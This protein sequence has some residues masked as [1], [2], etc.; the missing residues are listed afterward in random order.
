MAVIVAQS[1]VIGQEGA[2]THPGWRVSR[3]PATRNRAPVWRAVRGPD[4]AV[5]HAGDPVGREEPAGRNHLGIEGKRPSPPPCRDRAASGPGSGLPG[6]FPGGAHDLDLEI[7]AAGRPMVVGGS[8][9]GVAQGLGCSTTGRLRAG[10]EP[11][12]SFRGR[13][14]PLRD[15]ERSPPSCLGA[16]T[17][18]PRR[19]AGSVPVGGTRAVPNLRRKR[20]GTR[21]SAETYRSSSSPRDPRGNG[22]CRC[23]P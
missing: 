21:S 4:P 11:G 8:A 16:G 6:A 17:G 22:S 2:K 23:D 3:L 10:A 12:T 13:P 18:R 5:E 1:G 20:Q 15:A 7:A 14:S 19:T 9:L